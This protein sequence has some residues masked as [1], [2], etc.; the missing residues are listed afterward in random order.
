MSPLATTVSARRT[1]SAPMALMI[2]VPLMRARPSLAP[3]TMGLS[4]SFLSPS[5]AFMR[6]P[7]TVQS[8]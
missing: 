8:P 2:S 4:L 6:T 7:P 5:A 1:A 3:S